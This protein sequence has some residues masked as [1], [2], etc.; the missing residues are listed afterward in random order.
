M[1][2]DRRNN[3]ASTGASVKLH[4]ISTCFGAVTKQPNGGGS[5]NFA[6]R[7]SQKEKPTEMSLH[8]SKTLNVATIVVYEYSLVDF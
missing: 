8:W 5:K 3:P 6:F 4:P 2:Q 1:I 7:S